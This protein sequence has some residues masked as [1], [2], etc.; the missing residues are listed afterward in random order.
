M[1]DKNIEIMKKLIEDK[2]KK[3]SQQGPNLKPERSIGSVR[4]GRSNK[5]QGGQFDK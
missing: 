1:S 2:K 3:G 4:K 5:K